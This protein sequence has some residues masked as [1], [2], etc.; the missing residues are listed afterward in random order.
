MN[1]DACKI[2]NLGSRR[3]RHHDRVGRIISPVLAVVGI[4]SHQ[5][6]AIA[7]EEGDVCIVAWVAPTAKIV[8]TGDWNDEIEGTLKK[9]IDEFKKTGSW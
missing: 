9:A 1:V 8:A 4:V 6:L 7:E 5:G 2:A 3:D